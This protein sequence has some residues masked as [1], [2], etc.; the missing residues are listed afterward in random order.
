MKAS[1]LAALLLLAALWGGSFLFMR[2][3]V[4]VLGPVV[5]IEARVGVAGLALV[6]FALVTACLPDLRARWRQ[7]AVIGVLNSALPFT[8]IAAAELHLSASLAAVLNATAPLFGAL[9]AA[10]WIKERL[11]ARKLAGLALGLAGVLV[12]VGWS[13]LPR[14][15][16]VVLS[17]GASLLGALCYGLASVYT[18]VRVRGAQPLGLA[19]GSQLS[20]SVAL[21]PLVPF[22]LPSAQPSTTVLL[23]VAALA[24]LSTAL[25]YLLY[26][27]LIVN[28]GP[29]KAL[30]VTFL[31]PVFG[32]SWGALFL[33]DHISS[34]TLLGCAIIL[35]GTALV[36]GLRLRP[37]PAQ[38]RAG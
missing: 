13:P 27:R 6:A 38:P 37:A 25:A 3:A 12:L 15:W 8:L 1:D 2:V 18:R 31:T 26:F 30:T 28:V 4:P 16:E 23:C 24:L 35:A 10:A 14:T 19:I 21:L 36:T 29:T 22:A 20:A 11:T 9:I 5:L 17:I 33:G 34:S 7:Y 32:V